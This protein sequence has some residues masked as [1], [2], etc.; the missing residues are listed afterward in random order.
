VAFLNETARSRLG[1]SPGD[2]SRP[3]QDLEISY[4]P[5][6]LRGLVDRALA[7]RSESSLRD[8]Q[9]AQGGQVRV[10]NIFVTP[11]Y[12]DDASLLGT[13]ITFQDVTEYKSL[14]SELQHSKQEL[15][16]AYEELQS[17][18][19]ELETTNEELQSTIE[20]LETTNEELQSTNEELETMN[21]ELQSANEELQTINDEL[22]SRSTDLNSAHAFLESVFTSLRSGVVV[23]DRDLRVQVW[24]HRAEDLWGVRADEA[25]R[26]NFLGLDIGLP[27]NDLRPSLREI[28]SGSKEHAEVVLPATSR[29]GRP[30]ECRVIM[31]PLRGSNDGV[32]GVI[33]LME[34]RRNGESS[35]E[36]IR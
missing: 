4:R 31:A 12:A 34:E 3:L 26:A 36:S 1:L 20:E 13:R 22:R 9:W 7:D 21:E 28:L 14:E 16:T 35:Y 25:Q 29:R 27:V 30:L 33:L 15:E 2:L 18:N 8:V 17:T 24:N 5:A 11:L 6:D 10:Y 32:D 19:E 23:V